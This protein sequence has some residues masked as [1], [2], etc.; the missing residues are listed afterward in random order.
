MEGE[1]PSLFGRNWLEKV[2]L[3][4]REIAKVNE[5]RS[6]PMKEF[7]CIQALPSTLQWQ[8]HYATNTL[9]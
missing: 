5:K 7:A 6:S 3:D 1:G 2:N 4:W 9:S 8:K